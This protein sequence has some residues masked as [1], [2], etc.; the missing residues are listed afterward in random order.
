[1]VTS[2]ISIPVL[3]LLVRYISME[4]Q[5]QS[6]EIHKL[7]EP[8]SLV[9]KEDHELTPIV[10]DTTPTTNKPV[11]DIVTY[12]YTCP[13]CYEE[14]SS[15]KELYRVHGC[16]HLYCSR[17]I[18]TYYTNK[19]KERKTSIC[20]PSS[21]CNQDIPFSLVWQFMDHDVI[22][23]YQ[24]ILLRA[25]LNFK[26]YIW[27]TTDNCK[28]KIKKNYKLPFCPKCRIQVCFQCGEWWHGN[29]PCGEE[30]EELTKKKMTS[31][32]A[33]QTEFELWKQQ[34]ST[35]V[36]SCPKCSTLISRTEGCSH[37]TCRG[38]SHQFCWVC[39]K[40][41]KSTHCSS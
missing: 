33:Q 13:L 19:I 15:R 35:S 8:L 23:L 31:F 16:R 25:G 9:D 18:I 14:Y 7:V 22:I 32:L 20:C 28:T 39:L 21:G 2:S 6:Q 29:T 26:Q 36:K 11:K 34:N 17:C 37:M 27:C 5:V 41:T 3:F 24:R 40:P 38:C 10:N 12:P 4:P 30:S 1:M